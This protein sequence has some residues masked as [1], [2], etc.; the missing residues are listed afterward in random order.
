MASVQARR[1]QNRL[2]EVD[3]N[4]Y[5]AFAASLGAGLPGM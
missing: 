1:I 2:A 4:P 5:L 3:A